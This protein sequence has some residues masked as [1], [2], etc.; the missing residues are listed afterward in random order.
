M[1]GGGDHTPSPVKAASAATFG[2]GIAIAERAEANKAT[3]LIRVNMTK[4]R[5]ERY[6]RKN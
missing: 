4:E 3:N 6:V 2:V 1:S 5:V